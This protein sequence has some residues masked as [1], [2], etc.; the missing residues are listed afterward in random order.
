MA[1]W[2]SDGDPKLLAAMCAKMCTTAY[3][4]FIVTQDGDHLGNKFRNRTLKLNIHLPMGVFDVSIIHLQQLVKNVQKSVHGLS[5][6]DVCPIDRMNVDSFQKIISDRVLEALRVHIEKS[7][8]TIQYLKIARDITS[9]FL[10]HDLSPKER[11]FRMW[12]GVYF[13]RIW[14]QFILSSKKYTLKDNF[15]TSNTYVSSELNARNLICLIKKFRDE[16]RERL[17]LPPLFDSQSCEKMFRTFRSMGTAQY[18]KINF[19]VHE[20]MYMIGRVEVLNE[21]AYIEL[22]DEK[23]IFPN[24]R[25]GKTTI[26]PLPSDYE[27][28][29]TIANARLEAITNAAKIGMNTVNNIDEYEFRYNEDIFDQMESDEESPIEDIDEYEAM[30][31]LM[32][33]DNLDTQSCD[34]NSPFVIIRDEDGIKRKIRKSTYI[35]MLSE[36]SERISNDRLRRVQVKD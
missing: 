5:Q 7:D 30:Q 28:D 11:I 16:Q 32:D 34:E 1:G 3:G 25:T 19:S 8:A 17:F 24:K 18:T 23:I 13:L 21:I 29:A 33:D 14:R 12:H 10:L 15:I 6:I 22:A 35:W 26:Y 36:P 27:I 20:L 9:S 4:S 31:T 2:S